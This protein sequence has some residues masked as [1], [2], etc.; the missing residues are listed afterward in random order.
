[1]KNLGPYCRSLV[2]IGSNPGIH[3]SKN[4]DQTRFLPGTTGIRK[5]WVLVSGIER[6]GFN[7]DY[8]YKV[9]V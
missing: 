1:M 7:S 5:G 4:E 3:A 2:L 6:L 8:L 9:K